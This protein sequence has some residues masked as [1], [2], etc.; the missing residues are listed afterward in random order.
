MDMERRIKK[1]VYDQSRS[2]EEVHTKKQ[3]EDH[4]RLMRLEREEE[5]EHREQERLELFRLQ[6]Q[7]QH[8]KSY[9]DQMELKMWAL[10][11]TISW[12]E[13]QYEELEADLAGYRAKVLQHEPNKKERWGNWMTNPFVERLRGDEVRCKEA[14]HYTW[15]EFEKFCNELCPLIQKS[16]WRPA[17]K[18]ENGQITW[19]KVEPKEGFESVHPPELLL[20]VTF[21]WCKTGLGEGLLSSI[22]PPLHQRDVLPFVLT[23]LLA[24]GETLK[25]EIQWPTEE[26][27]VKL[28]GDLK[29]MVDDHF[30][31]AYTVVD[32]TETRVTRGP[33]KAKVPGQQAPER[34]QYSVKKK[35]HS[36][37]W[38]LIVLLSGVIIYCSQ[39]SWVHSD[40]E[41]WNQEKLREKYLHQPWFG[42]LADG[43]YTPNPKEILTRH[44]NLAIAGYKPTPR[45]T[46][47]KG[48]ARTPLDPTQAAR[49]KALSQSR[50]VV[51]NVYSRCKHWEVLRRLPLRG[52][53]PYKIAVM[54]LV[55]DFLIPLVGRE[56]HASP[57]RKAD[58]KHPNKR[59]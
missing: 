7:V 20:F 33:A 59:S 21:F 25:K 34:E 4:A 30:A 28:Q 49:N 13:N 53:N 24:C 15:T 54:N 44:Q 52:T 5:R 1:R 43:G 6:H 16:S 26:E 47:P 42:V 50:V 8:L 38:T 39:A 23:T 45:N 27:Q 40:Q 10:E 9:I 14:I 37:C 58:W 11:E 29:E 18:E 48:K 12:W 19:Q 46:K 55:L 17:H 51:E 31:G 57:Q 41:F 22:M 32:G 56:L 3:K 2:K 35:Q 36:L